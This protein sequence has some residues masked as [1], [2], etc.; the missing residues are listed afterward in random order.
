MQKLEV[1][2]W[3]VCIHCVPKAHVL[4]MNKSLCLP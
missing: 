3:L 1:P 4:E 2:L